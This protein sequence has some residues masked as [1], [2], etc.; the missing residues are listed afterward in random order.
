MRARLRGPRLRDDGG[1]LRREARVQP[2][3]PTRDRSR[4]WQGGHPVSPEHD[5]R[6]LRRRGGAAPG[7]AR[8][9]PLPLVLPPP[10]RH[11]EADPRLPA[12]PGPE[13][14]PS[15]PQ[16]RPE[17]EGHH[18]AGDRPRG[19]VQAGPLRSRDAA[20]AG[21]AHAQHPDAP[22]AL[23]LP[24]ARYPPLPAQDVPV[25][26][27]V[28]RAAPA[29]VRT[30]DLVR[31]PRRQPDVAADAASPELDPADAGL[32]G[33]QAV[34]RADAEQRP[35]PP[36]PRQPRRGGEHRPHAERPHV[37]AVAAPVVPASEGVSRPQRA[38]GEVQLRH[39]A[40]RLRAGHQRKPI[41][42]RRDA[43][44]HRHFGHHH[45]RHRDGELLRPG[46]AAHRGQA[47]GCEP[48]R[49]GAFQL[50]AGARGEKLQAH[51]P[52]RA[53]AFGPRREHPADDSLDGRYPVLLRERRRAPARTRHVPG[54]PVGALGGLPGAVLGRRLLAALRP[55]PV[56]QRPEAGARR[57]VGGRGGVGQGRPHRVTPEEGG[58]RLHRGGVR[59]RGVGAAPRG[60][61][62]PP[63]QPAPPPALPEPASVPRVSHRHR[64]HLPV[65]EPGPGDQQQPDRDHP[66]ED[67]A[68]PPRAARPAD[69]ADRAAAPRHAPAPDQTALPCP[70]RQAG[71]RRR[72]HP[73]LHRAADDGGCQ[74]VGA[75]RGQRDPRPRRAGPDGRRN[76][77][78][79]D[80]QAR[81]EDLRVVRDLPPRG[82][83]AGG[84][85]LL[86]AP[87]R[88]ALHPVA[89]LAPLRRDPRLRADPRVPGARRDHDLGRSPPRAGRYPL[90]PTLGDRRAARPDLERN[91]FQ[92]RSD[93]ERFQ[94]AR[95]RIAACPPERQ[96]SRKPCSDEPEEQDV[97]AAWLV[98]GER[99]L[100]DVE[101]GITKP[102]PWDTVRERIAERLRAMRR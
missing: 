89:A 82:L 87:R 2:P 80:R 41:G 36:H 13:P 52:R 61:E 86:P 51:G 69:Q 8:L 53:A 48:R 78:P 17:P 54:L 23:R 5:D 6:R 59:R 18:R 10:H 84:P 71:A 58:A 1:R 4:R 63:D 44:R 73:D 15:L 66:E 26:H 101:R 98:E 55:A 49:G 102:V 29:G 64:N 100:A 9:P 65:G 57:A 45:H 74:R 81:R 33:R 35:H 37:G 20:L 30:P 50:L 99:R 32:D 40:P 77:R 31:L 24:A 75:P 46:A 62:E 94:R 42:E 96:S 27:L 97:E 7:R 68:P 90:G 91:G 79:P 38:R 39:E 88:E 70:S 43:G 21:G 34:R 60:A 3:G 67:L 56:E 76:D 14:D 12:L 93:A 11:D 85:R 72:L 25:H 83:R 28:P 19:W 92:Y 16:R 47:A 95:A 22:P